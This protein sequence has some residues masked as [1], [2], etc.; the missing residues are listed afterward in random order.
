MRGQYLSRCVHSK[1]HSRLVGA[2]GGEEGT[3]S[4]LVRLRPPASGRLAED[5]FYGKGELA[6]IST[7]IDEARGVVDYVVIDGAECQICIDG[8]MERRCR[9]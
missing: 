3:S 6:M 4:S 1:R 2:T 7:G 8:G 5:M 9:D